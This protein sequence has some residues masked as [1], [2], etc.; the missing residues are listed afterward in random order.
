MHTTR[1]LSRTRIS[2]LALW[3]Q[4]RNP[5]LPKAYHVLSSSRPI[6][7]PASYRL[8]KATSSPTPIPNLRSNVHRY[9][10]SSNASVISDPNRPDLF[11]H[12]VSLPSSSSPAYALSFLKEPPPTPDSSTIIGWLPAETEGNG[13]DQEAGLNDF[14]ENPKFRKVLHDAIQTGLREEVDDVQ[15]NGA[16]QLQQGWMHIH[17]CRNVPALGRIGDPDD[18]LASVLVEEGKL[19]P[20]TY[21]AMP[22]YRTCTADGPM[23]LTDGLAQKL[24]ST[25]AK[26]AAAESSS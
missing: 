6:Y 16:I 11:Y 14:Q 9:Y 10:S 20:E 25:L 19:L 12:L 21:Q 26:I 22:S 23:Q 3:Y 1:L 17:D 4:C 8:Q 18:I 7:W 2:S 13:Q 24:K 15:K 5:I